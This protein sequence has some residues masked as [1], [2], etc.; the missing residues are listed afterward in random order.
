MMKH[1]LKTLF[2]ALLA[3]GFLLACIVGV[4]LLFI[5]APPVLWSQSDSWKPR[6][7]VGVIGLLLLSPCLFIIMHHRKA[8]RVGRSSYTR[9]ACL[10]LAGPLWF[11]CL[12]ALFFAYSFGPVHYHQY[13]EWRLHETMKVGEVRKLLEQG[14]TISAGDGKNKQRIELQ[15]IEHLNDGDMLELYS[16][17]LTGGGQPGDYGITIY[18]WEYDKEFGMW[19]IVLVFVCLLISVTS[20]WIFRRLSHI[21]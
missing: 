8:K 9:I 13:K 2:R 16:T 20:F 3:A 5:T 6:I 12:G 10:T 14:Y 21:R 15:D 4:S 1:I 11:I 19:R 7:L 18:K 17:D